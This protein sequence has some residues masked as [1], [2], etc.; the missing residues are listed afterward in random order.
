MPSLYLVADKGE[1]FPYDNVKTWILAQPDINRGEVDFET[2]I[3][4]ALANEWPPEVVANQ[5]SLQASGKCF[6]FEQSS[7]PALRGALYVDN[8]YFSFDDE[9]HTERCMGAIEALAAAQGLK[10]SFGFSE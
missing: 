3:A 4:T 5:R 8:V 1:N 6:T 7:S 2:T 10:K 9:P